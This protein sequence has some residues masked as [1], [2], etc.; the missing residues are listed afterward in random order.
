MRSSAPGVFVVGTATACT[1]DR[2]QIFI[3]NCHDHALRVVAAIAGR[4]APQPAPPIP[5][6]EV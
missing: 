5:L 1:Q 3:E 6:P 2:F 4:P